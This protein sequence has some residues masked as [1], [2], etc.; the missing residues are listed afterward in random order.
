MS[1][2]CLKSFNSTHSAVET[3]SCST[4]SSASFFSVLHSGSEPFVRTTKTDRDTLR[5][6]SLVAAS[7]RT[8]VRQ[9]VKY[10]LCR[11]CLELIRRVYVFSLKDTSCRNAPWK[12]SWSDTHERWKMDECWLRSMTLSPCQCV[13]ARTQVRAPPQILWHTYSV[14][15]CMFQVEEV[16]SIFSRSFPSTWPTT[17]SRSRNR[18]HKFRIR[19][20]KWIDTT[21]Y[22]WRVR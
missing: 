1:L 19:W 10:D 20:R 7:S 5:L 15:T 11:V 6:T 8:T 14:Q 17:T 22:I 12:P 9:T 3:V 18:K 4:K 2:N 21:R 16:V 13:C